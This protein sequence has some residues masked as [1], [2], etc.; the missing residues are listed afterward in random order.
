MNQD[1]AEARAYFGTGRVPERLIHVDHPHTDPGDGRTECDRCGKWVWA[2]T[3]S[4]K[5]VPV[6]EAAWTR[7]RARNVEHNTDCTCPCTH[8]GGDDHS[9]CCCE[10]NN[11]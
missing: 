8:C 11:S 9:G 3:H 6:T 4:C 2:V 7:L 1:E 10:G 5:G